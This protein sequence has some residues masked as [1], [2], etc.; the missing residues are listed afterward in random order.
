MMQAHDDFDGFIDHADA[1]VILA[2][3]AKTIVDPKAV[4]PKGAFSASV[5]AL[6]PI[7]H[8]H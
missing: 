2:I 7:S 5:H 6:Y 4:Q 3:P 1:S 8:R